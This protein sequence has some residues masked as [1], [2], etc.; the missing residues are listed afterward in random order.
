MCRNEGGYFPPVSV[1]TCKNK[2]LYSGGPLYSIM[3]PSSGCAIY[4]IGVNH[5][6]VL[7]TWFYL[8]MEMSK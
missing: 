4:Y 7:G 5:V 6:Q 2:V 3:M 1:S 8:D